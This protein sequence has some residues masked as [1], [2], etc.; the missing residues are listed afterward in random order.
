M[1]ARATGVGHSKKVAQIFA[2]LFLMLLL[3]SECS[4]LYL[5]AVPLM[6]Q[7]RSRW[8]ARFPV[9][10][11]VLLLPSHPA[12]KILVHVVWLTEWSGFLQEE[13]VHVL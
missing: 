3:P 11:D 13:Y 10:L 8:D 6:G 1:I 9:L 7:R 4:S 5:Q 12:S 2:P